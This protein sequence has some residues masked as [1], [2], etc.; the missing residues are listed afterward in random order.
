MSWSPRSNDHFDIC[1][2]I[3]NPIWVPGAWNRPQKGLNI[4]INGK[5]SQPYSQ[6]PVW[7]QAYVRSRLPSL[8]FAQRYMTSDLHRVLLPW[9]N[10]ATQPNNMLTVTLGQVI[11]IISCNGGQKRQLFP[12]KQGYQNSIMIPMTPVEWNHS[13]KAFL[14][15]YLDRSLCLVLLCQSI[16]RINSFCH[17]V[18][19]SDLWTKPE[20]SHFSSWHDYISL[21]HGN[22]N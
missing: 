3:L 2:P 14:G 17:T 19:D 6:Y 18:T 22:G 1:E 11:S 4:E 9:A 5:F 7:A 12:I 13:Q 16:M 15:K 10:C 8:S 21:F 20:I